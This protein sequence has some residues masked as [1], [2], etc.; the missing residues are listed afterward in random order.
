M[1]TSLRFSSVTIPL[2]IAVH[3]IPVPKGFVKTSIS[4]GCAPLFLIIL[5]GWTMPLTTIP[6]L[7]SGSSMVCPPRMGM[8]ASVKLDAF[9][10][11]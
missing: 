2:F 6:Y 9:D 7:G 8:P 3:K 5:A 10:F 11:N 4:P 1:V